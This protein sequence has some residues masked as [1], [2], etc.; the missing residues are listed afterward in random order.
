MMKFQKM[1]LLIVPM[2]VSLTACLTPTPTPTPE[3]KPA[4][5]PT[6]P[7]IISV[8]PPNDAEGMRKDTNITITF[9][10]AM[11]K[12]ATQA[13]YQ[14]VDI[15]AGQVVFGWN[16]AGTVLTIDP[17]QDLTYREVFT[18][19]QTA[20]SY[21]FSLSKAAKSALNVELDSALDSSFKTYKLKTL[22]AS[23]ALPS[24]DIHNNGAVY[25]LDTFAV[26]DDIDNSSVRGFLTFDFSKIPATVINSEIVNA[27]LYV[28]QTEF[29]GTPIVNLFYGGTLPTIVCLKCKRG[30]TVSSVE[31][32]S[33]LYKTTFDKSP[34]FDLD[35]YLKSVN[36]TG[37]EIFQTFI[38]FNTIDATKAFNIDF[39]NRIS[40][41]DKSQYRIEIPNQTNSDG[42]ADFLRFSLKDSPPYLQIRY[43]SK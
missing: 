8:D 30:L 26:G 42:V 22:R 19:S 28:N 43:L 4:S 37:G 40:L 16:D 10:E 34:R 12:A 31:I 3:P 23:N 20:N 7:K 36:A 21:K 5:T 38:G 27:I 15:P 2:I 14:S 29:V 39:Q 6:A 41:G 32:G 17:N 13:A 11:D 18:G 35:G 33:N 25:T 1:A 9:S 24:G